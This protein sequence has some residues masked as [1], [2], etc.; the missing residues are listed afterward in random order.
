MLVGAAFLPRGSG[1]MFIVAGVAVLVCGWRSRWLWR[2]TTHVRRFRT[3]SEGPIVLHYAPE[4][5]GK[6]DVRMLLRRCRAELDSLAG[7]FGSP[8]R[9]R[10]VVFLVTSH[11]DIGRIFGPHYGGTALPCANAIVIADDNYVRES[12]RHEFAHLFSGRWSLFAPP[13]LSEGLSVWL[14]GTEWGQP[15]DR[16]ARPLLGD[17]SLTLHLLLRPEF[18]FAEQNRY[19]CYALAG[20]FSGFLIRRYGWERY[21]NLFRLCGRGGFRKT[22]EKCFGVSLEKAEWRWRNEIRRSQ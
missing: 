13:L 4:L 3:A 12:M 5:N 16:A 7:G 15:I 22:F 17:R 20:S 19:S 6:W 8:L 21:R 1:F 10:A 14:Q 2:F 18:F 11:R 9:G